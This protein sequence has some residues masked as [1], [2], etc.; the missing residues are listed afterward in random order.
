M[1][2]TGKEKENRMKLS[3]YKA[4]STMGNY[5]T[6]ERPV[7]IV[8]ME[9]IVNKSGKTQL[10]LT[11]K[12]GLGTEKVSVFDSGLQ[13]VHDEYPFAVP[14]AVVNLKIT[15]KDPFYNAHYA[16]KECREPFDLTEIAEKATENDPQKF[17]DYILK[18]V[19]SSARPAGEYQPIAE[20]AKTVYEKRKG[21]IL[22][23]SSAIRMHHTGLY[24]NIVHTAEVVNVCDA[25]LKTTLGK[26]I[27]AELL[28]TGAALH[29]IGKL[30]TYDTDD[31]GEATMTLE[32]YAMGS[33]HYGSLMAV[34]EAVREGNYDPERVLLLK[35]IIAS[36][37][38]KREFGDLATP[39]T[40]EGIWLNFADDLDAKHYEARK[41]ILEIQPGTVTPKKVFPFDFNLYRRTDQ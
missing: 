39:L 26:D 30:D 4:L 20:I 3:D 12:D 1:N 38:G 19:L 21:D 14:G 5:E 33:H 40:L 25:L 29:D 22:R 24:G 17:Y 23:S 8:S 18:T 6:L 31:I 15:K 10:N 16:F 2:L 9:E 7:Y 36:H 13:T 35:N 28:L 27:D 34:E 11:V 37:H 41:A 32:G